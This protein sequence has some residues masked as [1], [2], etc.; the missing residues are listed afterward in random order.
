PPIPGAFSALGLVTSDLKR[1]YVRTF[2]HRA[3]QATPDQL[4]QTNANMRVENVV[5]EETAKA[6]RLEALYKEARENLRDQQYQE[7]GE[8]RNKFIAERQVA[9]ENL[10]SQMR[11]RETQHSVKITSMQRK[12]Q[13]EVQD[14]KDN[15][16][17]DK[18]SKDQNHKNTVESMV[19]QHERDKE[20]QE[21]RHKNQLSE[22]QEGHRK[23][24]AKINQRHEDQ[25]NQILRT[26]RMS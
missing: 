16:V 14:L 4:A 1:D 15:M 10:K 22:I 11:E 12:H 19:A 18:R 13:K 21:M 9:V 5:E 8:L 26:S 24:I 6:Q 25:L 23:E 3:D 17:R 20:S 7:I 2:Y